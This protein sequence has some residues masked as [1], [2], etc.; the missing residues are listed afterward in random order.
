MR[1]GSP[2]LNIYSSSLCYLFSF[3]QLSQ[4]KY[5]LKKS[6][7]KL[8]KVL[9]PLSNNLGKRYVIDRVINVI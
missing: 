6:L 4:Q 9:V 7:T 8:E 1:L 3:E 2:E 5:A